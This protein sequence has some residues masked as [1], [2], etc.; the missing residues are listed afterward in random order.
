MH[1]FDR[2][3]YIIVYLKNRDNDFMKIDLRNS[4]IFIIFKSI[5]EI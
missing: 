5:M 2:S 1:Y 3:Y 4:R